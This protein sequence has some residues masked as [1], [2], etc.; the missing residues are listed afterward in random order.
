MPTPLLGC[1]PSETV[2]HKHQGGHAETEETELLN[3]SVTT[4]HSSLSRDIP[5]FLL[6]TMGSAAWVLPSQK[7]VQTASALHMTQPCNQ[8]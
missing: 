7:S 4:Q 1:H 5:A 6:H 3:P 8:G 2:A